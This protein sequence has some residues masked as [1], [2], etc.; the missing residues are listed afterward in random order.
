MKTVGD[1]KLLIDCNPEFET[2]NYWI[3]GDTT[4]TAQVTDDGTCDSGIR[5]CN[6]VVTVDG[7]DSHP[8][9]DDGTWGE[10]DFNRTRE[11]D[12]LKDPWQFSYDS[13]HHI[14]I[15]C[16]DWAG[17]TVSIE[18]T[19]KVDVTDPETEL[20]WNGP[21]KVADG[22]NWIDG[23]STL[24]LHAEDPEGPL[25]EGQSCNIGVD[26]TWYRVDWYTDEHLGSTGCYDPRSCNPD[27]YAEFFNIYSP[28]GE[29]AGCIEAGQ[30]SCDRD[31][32]RET[33]DWYDCVEFFAHEE[34]RIDEA[35]K[36]WRG[37]NIAKL[38]ES[39]HVLSYFSVDHIGNI[40]DM[41]TECFFVDKTPPALGKDLS[42]PQ[43][44]A[45]PPRPGSDDECFISSGTA[46]V[47]PTT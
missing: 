7:D 38:E 15:V 32:R 39:C 10:F 8:E 9:S 34:C 47:D 27:F 24:T 29:H 35:W 19:D 43:A 25:A 21:H 44:G 30:N 11:Y 13:K 2:C 17:N 41:N 37:D 33:D 28:Y 5:Y 22:Q 4:I 20:I 23:V 46:T 12:N 3:N 14:S 16:E 6:W 1:P 40:E 31:F 18:E 26:K 42:G 36:L 45:C